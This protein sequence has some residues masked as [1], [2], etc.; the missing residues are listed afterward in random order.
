MTRYLT[1]AEVLD[2]H[3]SVIE[4]W[5]GSGGIRGINVLESTLAQ[6]RQS[7]A[8]KIG[9]IPHFQSTLRKDFMNINWSSGLAQPYWPVCDAGGAEFFDMAAT[10]NAIL[11][12]LSWCGTSQL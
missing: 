11:S 2:L 7:F 3:R 10:V 8:K 4:R 6:P 1:F 12:E 5:G 9:D